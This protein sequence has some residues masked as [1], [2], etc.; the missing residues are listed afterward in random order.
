MVPLKTGLTPV[1]LPTVWG[2]AQGCCFINGPNEMEERTEWPSDSKSLR[3][4]TGTWFSVFLHPAGRGKGG[5]SSNHQSD[6]LFTAVSVSSAL[7]SPCPQPS[8]LIIS[9]STQSSAGTIICWPVGLKPLT[10]S[11]SVCG[12]CSWVSTCQENSLASFKK[13]TFSTMTF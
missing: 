4:S 13:F 2:L 10:P 12:Y 11:I 9:L 5:S 8:Q 6:C 3:N 7:A 1:S